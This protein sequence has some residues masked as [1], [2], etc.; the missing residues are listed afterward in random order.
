[1]EHVHATELLSFMYIS[2]LL[3][4]YYT[5]APHT[6]PYTLFVYPFSHFKCC[7]VPSPLPEMT[8]VTSKV[9]RENVSKLSIAHIPHDNP[10]Q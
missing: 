4:L 7:L 6:H 3:Y 8:A 2:S 1:M 10:R 9:V 5:A